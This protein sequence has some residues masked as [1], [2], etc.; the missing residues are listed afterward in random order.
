MIGTH[1]HGRKT[2]LLCDRAV[3]LS[4]AKVH[5]FSDSVLCL[6][7]IKEPSETVKKWKEQLEWFTTTTQYKELGR[8]DGEPMEFEWKIFPGFT[9]L[10]I[11]REIQNMMDEM[12]CDPEE[13]TGRI[14]FMSMF[15][16]NDGEMEEKRRVCREFHDGIRMRK[17]ISTWSLVIPRTWF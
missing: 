12:Q 1:V 5:I 4:T 15:N 6:G 11:I 9:T 7:K 17:K 8:I 14:I 13:F 16:D 3:R 10:Q 2:T